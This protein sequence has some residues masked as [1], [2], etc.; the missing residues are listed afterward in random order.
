MGR[1]DYLWNQIAKFGIRVRIWVLFVDVK[2]LSAAVA[3]VIRRE[4]AAAD[5]DIAEF[6]ERAG[7][8]KSTGWRQI[9]GQSRMSIDDVEAFA[10]ALG[11]TLERLLQEAKA[12]QQPAAG[13]GEVRLS[14]HVIAQLSPEAQAGIREAQRIVAAEKARRNP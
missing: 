12:E 14:E 3:T 8:K 5:I 6:V 1:A 10:V 13:E 9:K 2:T 7:K 4:L 11:W